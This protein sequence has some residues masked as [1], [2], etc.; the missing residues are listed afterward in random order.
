[1]LSSLAVLLAQ[2]LLYQLFIWAI[3]DSFYFSLYYDK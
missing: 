3:N 2:Y 1:M